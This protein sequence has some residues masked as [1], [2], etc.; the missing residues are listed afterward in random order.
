VSFPIRTPDHRTA[1]CIGVIRVICVVAALSFGCLYH[2]Q[3]VS[4]YVV[5]SGGLG[6]SEFGCYPVLSGDFNVLAVVQHI[7]KCVFLFRRDS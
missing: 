2:A 5:S 4:T 3:L 7:P 6:L 1:M